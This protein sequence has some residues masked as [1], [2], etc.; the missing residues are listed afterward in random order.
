MRAE[1]LR[2]VR[3]TGRALARFKIHGPASGEICKQGPR[4]RDRNAREL[5]REHIYAWTAARAQELEILSEYRHFP[6]TMSDVE[7]IGHVSRSRGI[8]LWAL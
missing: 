1:S 4:L 8:Y 6:G 3:S 5:E 2:R 7:P